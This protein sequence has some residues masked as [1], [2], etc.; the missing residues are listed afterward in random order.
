M[1]LEIPNEKKNNEIAQSQ[2]QN[3]NIIEDYGVTKEIPI[4]EQ[5]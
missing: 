2:T 4:I 1:T 5:K 3:V